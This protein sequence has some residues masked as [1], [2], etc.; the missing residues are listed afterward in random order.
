MIFKINSLVYFWPHWVFAV[1]HGLFVAALGLFPSWVSGGYSLV[2]CGLLIA[3]GS[4]V[5]EH[6][7]QVSWASTAVAQAQ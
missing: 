6:G 4:L 5:T 7:L 3:V 1:V 2:V